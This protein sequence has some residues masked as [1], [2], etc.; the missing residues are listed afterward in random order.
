LL[1]SLLCQVLPHLFSHA[2]SPEEGVRNMVS[3]CLGTL[4]NLHPPRVIGAL[5]DLA[6]KGTQHGMWTEGGG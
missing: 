6:D 2:Q 4:S 3:E 5:K 1:F